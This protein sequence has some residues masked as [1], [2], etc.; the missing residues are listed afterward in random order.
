MVIEGFNEIPFSYD[1]MNIIILIYI[2][3]RTT[4]HKMTTETSNNI[5]VSS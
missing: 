3:L 2:T 4:S 5:L 1:R